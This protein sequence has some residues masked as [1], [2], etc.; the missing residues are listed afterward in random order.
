MSEE[1]G[2]LIGKRTQRSTNTEKHSYDNDVGEII[3]EAE[4]KKFAKMKTHQ[5]TSQNENV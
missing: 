2:R 3:E 5:T 4:E 1:S